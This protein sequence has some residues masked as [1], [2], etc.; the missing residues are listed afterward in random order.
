MSTKGK[1]HTRERARGGVRVRGDVTCAHIVKDRHREDA[2]A[3]RQGEAPA[4]PHPRSEGG[5]VCSSHLTKPQRGVVRA[6]QFEL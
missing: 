2:Y 4:P 1:G 6:A 3:S 5:A